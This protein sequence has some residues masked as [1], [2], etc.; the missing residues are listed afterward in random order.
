MHICPTQA[1]IGMQAS[2]SNAL[3]WNYTGFV[4]ITGRSL[5]RT[6]IHQQLLL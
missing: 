3:D 4:H 2:E 6:G 5:R 1:F